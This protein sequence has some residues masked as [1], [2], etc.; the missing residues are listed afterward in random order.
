[1]TTVDQTN[2][3]VIFGQRGVGKTSFLN[4]LKVY[5]KNSE[6]KFLD[7]DQE[8][9]KLTQKTTSEIFSRE[10]EAAFRKYEWD[11]FNNLIKSHE[12]LVLTL[13]GGFPVEKIPKGIYC[14][15]LQRFSDESGRIFTDRPRLNPELTD[16]EE[17]LSRSKTRSIQFKKRADEIYFLSEGLDYPNKIEQNIFDSKFFFQNSYL[18]LSEENCEQR[19]FLKKIGQSGFELRDDLL[20]HEKMQEL[21]SFLSPQHLILSFRDKKQ[22][23]K[24]FETFDQIHR[25]CSTF[26]K[27]HIHIDW[28]LELGPPDLTSSLNPNTISLHEFLPGERLDLFLDRLEKSTHHFG[29]AS[30]APHLKAS[31]IINTWKELF[32]LWDWQRKDPLNRSIL[33]RS[34]NGQ[35]NWFRQL[36]CFKQKINFWKVSQGSAFDQPTL[37]QTQ[38]L[39][40][41]I[42]TWAALLGKPVT[43]SK[44]PIEQQTFFSA[45]EMPVL[46]IEIS[47]EEFSLAIP[48]LFQLGLRAAAVTSPLKLKAFEL[49]MENHYELQKLKT[50]ENSFTPNPE[51]IEFK[52]INTLVLTTNS[53]G[54]LGFEVIGTNTDVDGFA[55][56]VDFI[57]E[58]NST[59]I[60][61]W[62]G[63]GTLPVIKKI[64]PHAVEFSVRTKK[65]RDDKESLKDP[66]ILIWAAAPDAEPPSDFIKNPALI[67]DLNYKESSLAR[68]YAKNIKAQYLSGDL[69]FKEQAKK[70]REFWLPLSHLFT[71]S[72][73]R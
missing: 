15:W 32:L 5:W 56:C 58:K 29:T 71:A 36:M 27:N 25:H 17:F 9:E 57:K 24:S 21:I 33:P 60:A 18:T 68:A 53:K 28:A 55:K 61:I 44:T 3:L 46:A 13:G 54:P 10:G 16:L 43:H 22:T 39:P 20:S 2:Q 11:I 64:L 49:V 31:P 8:I 14:L 7:L 26:S 45:H 38:A 62:G 66:E 73:D 50:A 42:S 6:F 67:I 37:Y 40:R 70:Q 69:M 23:K 63:G 34:T 65:E 30:A 47:E 41:R 12:K 51:A 72:K 52:S 59:R 4:R 19:L 35:W 1:M 48:F